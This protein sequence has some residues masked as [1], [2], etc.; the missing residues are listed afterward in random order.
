M[1]ITREIRDEVKLS[2]ASAITDVLTEDT[3]I[4]TIVDKVSECVAKTLKD[5]V[6]SL[7]QK[8]DV[9]HK[10]VD[11]EKQEN[12]VI[13]DALRKEIAVLKTDQMSAIKK[14]QLLEH[15][16]KMC[17]LRI[18]NL[19]E[20]DGEN[21]AAVVL[22][23]LNSK[24]SLNLAMDDILVCQRIGKKVAKG[25]RGVLVKLKNVYTKDRVYNCKRLLKGTGVVI[26]E[27]LAE[28]KLKLMEAAIKKTSLRSVWST[29]GNIFAVKDFLDI[30]SAGK[31]D[32]IA[33]C[34]TWLTS[35]VDDA[36]VHIANYNFVRKDRA[37][38]G[39]GGGVVEKEGRRVET[40]ENVADSAK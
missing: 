40:L 26:K 5:R 27:D 35:N 11:Q 7:E 29:R 21:T 33:L 15:E 8:V 19:V 12:Q 13:I 1:V 23:L 31:Y 34:E 9:I 2:V 24:M 25:P 39:R 3:F 32:I 36:E 28:A 14:I 38:D 22:K 30:V 18:F 6:A 10:R 4:K 16:S 37:D 20:I 17:N